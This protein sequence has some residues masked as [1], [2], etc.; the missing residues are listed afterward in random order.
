MEANP[1]VDDDTFDT[2]NTRDEQIEL[3]VLG[4]LD[5]RETAAVERLFR[6]DPA[7]RQR[8]RELR[9]VVSVLVLDVEPMEPPSGLR[10]RIL[11]A[12][13]AD[14]TPESV[15]PAPALPA[16]VSLAERRQ[17]NLTRWTPWLL[18]AALALALVSSLVWNAQLRS[19]LDAPPET[20]TF[21]VA[22]SGP[23]EGVAGTF[24]SLGDDDGAVLNLAGL[25]ALPPDRAYQ[26]WLIADG[27]PEPNVTFVPN[28]AGVATVSV[29]GEI[30]DYRIMAITVEQTGGSPVPT[31]DPI[32]TSD[33]TQTT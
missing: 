27:D 1:V 9:E 31:T 19:D 2:T 11:D 22:G 33:L 8:A 30:D 24:V 32:I 13:R 15:E 6:E 3:Y 14:L 29:P 20:V 26:V 18:A 5:E 28:A 12:A 4:L 10:A 21:A 16:P 7:A 17:R 23:A 25:A